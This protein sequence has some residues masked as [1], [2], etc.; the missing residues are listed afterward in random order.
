MGQLIIFII[1]LVVWIVSAIIKSAN[2]RAKRQLM[3]TRTEWEDMEPTNSAAPYG[4]RSARKPAFEPQIRKDS[5][6][7]SPFESNSQI[8]PATA[9]SHAPDNDGVNVAIDFDIRKAVLYSEILN[10]KFKEE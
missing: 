1:A 4:G 8:A 6:R 9:A 7:N 2:S 5:N 3:E 10:P